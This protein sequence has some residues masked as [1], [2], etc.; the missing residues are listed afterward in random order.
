MIG[1]T[2]SRYR[3]V[4][5]LGGGGMGVVYKAEDAELGRFVALKFLPGHLAQDPP[6]LERFRREARAASA[7][8]HPNICTIYE[9]GNT[10]DQ[11]YIVMECLEGAT[12][13]DRIAGRPMEIE[14]L[15]GVAI[16]IADALDAAH[17]K[18]IVHRD[19]KPANIFIT[20]RGHAKILDF[21][22]AKIQASTL[23]SKS[24]TQ[25]LL[26]TP[27]ATIGTVPY[28]SPEQSRGRDLDARS[29]LF[30]FGVVLYE[31]ATG[32]LPFRGESWAVIFKEILD[33]TPTPA[34]RL[35]PAVPPELERIIGRALEKDCD[36]RYQSA[37]DMRS[38]LQRLKRDSA[39]TKLSTVAA[40]KKRLPWIAG[41]ALVLI[42]AV[43]AAYF[44]LPRHTRTL[45]EKDT[46]VLADF[47]NT[48]GDPVFEGTL[49]QGLSAQLEQSPFL[50]LLSDQ[51]V[52]ETLTLMSKPQDS[53]LTKD[54]TREVC[55]RT[56]STATVE[57]SI[58]RLDSQY[59]LGL[60]AVDCHTGDVL[61]EEQV[62][63]KGKE[64]VINALGDA[65][66]KL[67][68]K[69]GESLVS[70]QKYDVPLENV[71][72]P[73]L[74]ALQ[75]Y[76]FGYR[77][78]IVKSDDTGAIPFFQKATNLDPN[79]AMAYA[80]LGQNYIN[81]GESAR[82]AEST[83]KAYELRGR[84]S[85][86]EKLAIA[87]S[88]EQ[89]VTG[90]LE[91][92]RAAAELWA[93][94]YPRDYLPQV[95]LLITYGSMGMYDKALAAARESLRLNPLSTVNYGNVV[96]TY[97]ILN[98]L[99]EAKATAE[100]AR[101]HGL[102]GPLIH[103]ILYLVEFLQHHSE[104]MEREAGALMGKPGYEDA[105]LYLE[106]ETAAYGGEYAK[107]RELTARAMD[108]AQRAGQMETVA[109][110]RAS[111]ALREALVGNVAL[112]KE[113]AET[114]LALTNS[115]DVEAIVAITLG[116]SGDSVQAPH[117]AADLGKRF[118]TDTIVQLQYLPMIHSAAW[119]QSGAAGKAVEAL[120][121][122]APYEMGVDGGLRAVYLRG[123]AYLASK[124]GADAE[125]EFRKI[126]DHPSIVTN[127]PIG[128]LAHLG[129]GRSYALAGDEARAKTA[130]QDFFALWKNA[131]PDISIL[132]QARAEYA[133]LK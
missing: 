118:A 30:S 93:Q 79:F 5:R 107:A 31:M 131:D 41:S 12:L 129:L 46:I 85:E 22:L 27:G 122:A 38:D 3:I 121:P 43:G 126:I 112:A 117:L 18:G 111:A 130:Y 2:V 44:Y 97:L 19:I 108:S 34:S 55:Q 83:R 133:K 66:S 100:E 8:N 25:S 119:L 13:K 124:L 127:D 82:A 17:S 4:Q 52:F 56:S 92:A 40:P 11:S 33:G 76:S 105:V 78:T 35:N 101:A 116:L 91:G 113:A 65:A 86:R 14:S 68:G 64:Q 77:A 95:S 98:R 21:G 45:T 125:I 60:K 10:G 54:L 106:S 15:L 1:E 67:R 71:T 132:K 69:L 80:M 50:N 104:G 24:D 28:M 128:A 99:D 49:R 74:Q 20:E 51:R 123:Q 120:S 7:L 62:T 87:T 114:A 61:A 103:R 72:T 57:G 9:I 6:S 48:T 59:V 58:S 23:S 36:L 47:T 42:A 84:T 110:Y 89:L 75:A 90:N 29:D 39:S 73:S 70:V 16:Q 96:A 37:A 94:T 102:D 88:Y 32:V 26:T 115:K 109:G 53:R 63:A 81:L